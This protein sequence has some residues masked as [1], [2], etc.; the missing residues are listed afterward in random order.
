MRPLPRHAPAPRRVGLLGGSFNPAHEGHRHISL[1]ALRWLGLDQVWW[2]VSPL[3]PLKS[4]RDMASLP[5]RLAQARAMAADPRI[6]VGDPETRLGTRRS[7]DTVARLQARF[8]ATRFVW[9]MGADNLAQLHLWHRWT[10]LAARVPI[11]VF[12][13]PNYADRALRAPAARRL[14]GCRLRPAAAISLADRP[15]PAWIYFAIHSHP[16]SATA[17]RRG[18]TWRV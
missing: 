11:A 13:R 16:A 9:L 1:A 12:A 17:L 15:A 2:L 5:R 10:D 18:G 14:A 4:P 3:N 8:P 7:H 6:R